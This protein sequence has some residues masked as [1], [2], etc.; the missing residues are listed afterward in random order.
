M[1]QHSFYVVDVFAESKYQGNQLAVIRNAAD[2]TATE[3]QRIA[4]ESHF[5]ETTFITQ[6]QPENGGYNVR[7]FTPHQEVPFA[8]HPTLG[9]AYIIKNFIAEGNSDTIKL[10]LG[11]GQIP[12]TIQKNEAAKRCYG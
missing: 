1:P 9:T 2:L 4:N 12:V 8:G 5:S 3:M 11:V 10:N 7:I 6:D